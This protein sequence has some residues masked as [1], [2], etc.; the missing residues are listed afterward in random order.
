MC[1]K[2]YTCIDCRTSHDAISLLTLFSGNTTSLDDIL[3]KFLKIYKRFIPNEIS[4]QCLSME[5]QRYDRQGG[6]EEFAIY[7]VFL[8]MNIAISE[9]NLQSIQKNRKL[10][11][12]MSF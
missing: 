5:S 11:R 9:T 1:P 6:K 8:V 3:D 4:L 10:T 2:M 7:T 12:R